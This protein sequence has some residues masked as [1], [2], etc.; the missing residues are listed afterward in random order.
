M[1]IGEAFIEVKAKTDSF[2][3]E[4]AASGGRAGKGVASSLGNA[5]TGALAGGAA[6]A[7]LQSVISAA[8]DLEQSIGGT[9]AV[10]GSA[11]AAIDDFAQTSA[12]SVGL[13]EASFRSLA[14]FAGNQLKGLGLSAEEAAGQATGLIEIGADLAATFGGTTQ[15][16]V[17][18][19]S[20]T[21]RGEYDPVER[22]IAGL[23]ASTVAAK[24]VDMGL[25][26]STD[27]V[28]SYARAQATLA[29][30]TEGSADAQGQFAREADTVAG[31]QARAAAAFEN[32]QAA[33]GQK[34]TPAILSL[35]DALQQAM[36]LV[37]AYAGQLDTVATA[38]GAVALGLG[39]VA[40]VVERL[41][42]RLL[43]ATDGLIGFFDIVSPGGGIA[44]FGR[45][46]E[47]FGESGGDIADEVDE[48]AAAAEQ[49]GLE[50][51][52]LTVEEFAARL[53]ELLPA[54]VDAA[55]ALNRLGLTGDYATMVLAELSSSTSLGEIAGGMDGVAGSTDDA[56]AALERFNGVLD[57]QSA[58]IAA[59]QSLRDLQSEAF[60]A[61]EGGI[62]PGELDA[63]RQG[64]IGY[65]EDLRDVALAQHNGGESARDAAAAQR[66]LRAR[67]GEVRNEIPN[68]LLPMWDLL[69]RTLGRRIRLDADGEP[70]R[71]EVDRTRGHAG[72]F[73]DNRRF[74]A[75]FDGDPSGAR[76][77][78]NEADGLGRQW[79]GKSYTARFNAL[80]PQGTNI[81]SAAGGPYNAGEVHTVGERGPELFVSGESGTIINNGDY[82]RLRRNG[83]GG[84]WGG[85]NMVNVNVPGLVTA[86]IIE[87]VVVPRVMLE[88]DRAERRRG[89]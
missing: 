87:R 24:A 10:F 65:A 61:L 13:S 3:R 68:Q 23:R 26:E 29:L 39:P 42:T 81:L 2:E 12:D 59:R 36:P 79:D 69:T 54:G 20:A 22:Y 50:I 47:Q 64:V 9:E 27:S 84:G 78:Y 11:S 85:G 18:A 55:D 17:E 34:L 30:I 45:M 58:I 38:A 37:E 89:Y 66:D 60:G 53:Q 40:Y 35:A 7:G 72:R 57:E 32:A 83:G 43:D 33:I 52:G 74:T 70:A 86:E 63:L 4:V 21:F 73:W 14:S 46:A 56:T 80:F 44:A 25:A 49:L 16:A 88:L 62:D 8:S 1:K 75:D 71:G 31:R 5:V 51:D 77:A 15:E 48:I 82:S 28:S 19:L 41:N 76:N 6:L 67:M